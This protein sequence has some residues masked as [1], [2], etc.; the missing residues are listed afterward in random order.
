VTHAAKLTEEEII[1]TTLCYGEDFN[2]NL[3]TALADTGR[4]N[5]YHVETADQASAISDGE[6]LDIATASIP[7]D[8]GASRPPGRNPVVRSAIEE[9][10]DGRAARTCPL[11][12]SGTCANPSCGL[13]GVPL[14]D[15]RHP[16]LTVP[17]G[18]WSRLGIGPRTSSR[19]PWPP[20]RESPRSAETLESQNR[21]GAWM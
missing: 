14:F 2:E 7:Q 20:A 9:G 21:K 1:T 15:I 11:G 18:G 4:G 16:Q 12:L 13:R 5:A 3:L 17:T 8:G 19:P 10:L 6:V